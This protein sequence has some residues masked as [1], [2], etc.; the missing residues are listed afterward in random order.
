[1]SDTPYTGSLERGLFVAAICN[2]GG[3]LL[4]LCLLV[5]R[6]GYY[7]LA[8]FGLTQFLWLFPLWKYHRNNGETENAK[9]ILVVGGI[10]FLLNA[11]CWKAMGA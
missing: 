2:G 9:G 11:A 1:M 7:A 5:V 8:A 10:T 4:C 6:V 3:V